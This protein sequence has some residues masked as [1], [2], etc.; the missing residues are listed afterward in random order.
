MLRNGSLQPR[1]RTRDDPVKTRARHAIHDLRA[2]RPAQI[3]GD[4]FDPEDREISRETASPNSIR[5]QKI[6]TNAL[7]YNNYP[8]PPSA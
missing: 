6:D 3:H 1:L 2:Q 8:P 4:A 5:Q 7:F